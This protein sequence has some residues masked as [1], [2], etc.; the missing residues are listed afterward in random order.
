MHL[1]LSWKNLRFPHNNVSLAYANV[2][3]VCVFDRLTDTAVWQSV[4]CNNT[5][6]IAFIDT[7][8]RQYRIEHQEIC[9]CLSCFLFIICFA[10]LCRWLSALSLSEVKWITLYYCQS[11][12]VFNWLLDKMVEYVGKRLLLLGLLI[13]IR[14]YTFPGTVKGFGSRCLNHTIMS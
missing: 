6:V 12:L 3:K 7:V 4:T 10:V 9:I 2:F 1:Y 5:M 8:H 13:Y 11:M 14:C